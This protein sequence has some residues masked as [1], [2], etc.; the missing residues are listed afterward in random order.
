M[1]SLSA[2]SQRELTLLP[3]KLS[4]ESDAFA[5]VRDSRAR[6][7]AHG[8]GCRRLVDAPLCAQLI[9]DDMSFRT[10]AQHPLEQR[11]PLYSQRQSPLVQPHGTSAFIERMWDR[12]GIQDLAHEWVTVFQSMV[13]SDAG[14]RHQQGDSGR[15]HHGSILDGMKLLIPDT[16]LLNP[17]GCGL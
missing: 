12:F 5:Q 2:A 1:P 17:S 8:D 11:R 4:F 13:G 16:V 9:V 10:P 14:Q 3:E 7:T 15:S 6:M